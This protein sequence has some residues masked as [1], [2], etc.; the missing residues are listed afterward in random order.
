MKLEFQSLAQEVLQTTTRQFTESNKE[1]IGTILQPL[2]E[3][4][5]AFRK[6]VEENHTHDTDA[7]GRLFQELN[8]LR[9][10]NTQLSADAT[11]LARALRGNNKTAGTWGEMILD[12]VLAHSG[13]TEG[14]EYQRQA[15]NQNEDGQRIQPDVIVYYPQQQGVLI[16]DSKVS[17]KDYTDYCN[18]E[19]KAAQEQSA[20]AH[21]ASLQ[22]HIRGLSEKKYETGKGW[23]TPDFVLL[24]LPVEGA[25]TLALNHDPA[26]YQF[27]FERKIILITPSTL[28]ATLKLVRALWQQDRQNQNA[29]EIATRG[30]AL[31]DKFVLFYESLDEIEKGFQKTSDAF[32]QAKSRLKEG[33]GNL[34]RQAE[35]LRELGAKIAKPL[36]Q[37]LLSE[38]LDA[39][40]CPAAE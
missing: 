10:L 1:N 8:Q 32:H 22:A 19:E 35:Q 20:D 21:I 17:L 28:L 11:N 29:A 14:V 25:L 7:R 18:A 37:S 30:G 40:E 33:K 4:I 6:R 34:V 27:A 9:S 3:N 26:L 38:T 5:D 13:L 23:I 24:F 36:P 16:I 12:T 31:Y 2:R 15:S 39:G